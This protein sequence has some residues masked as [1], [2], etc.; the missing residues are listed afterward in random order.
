MG[1]LL[2][3]HLLPTVR[4]GMLRS[5]ADEAWRLGQTWRLSVSVEWV[6]WKSP[7][8]DLPLENLSPH[9]PI[10]P[11]RRGWSLGENKTSSNSKI[12]LNVG[13]NGLN[14]II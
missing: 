3:Y 7:D 10:R 11:E 6:R 13:L 9:H 2:C 8:D 4:F 14:W 5:W 1:G 12:F